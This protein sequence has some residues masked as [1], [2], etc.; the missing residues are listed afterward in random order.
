MADWHSQGQLFL[1]S[2]C[3]DK[4]SKRELGELGVLIALVGFIF[5]GRTNSPETLR[6]MLCPPLPIS[7][8]VSYCFSSE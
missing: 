5:K 3:A 2:A 6:D 1:V 8:D 7:P 4:G